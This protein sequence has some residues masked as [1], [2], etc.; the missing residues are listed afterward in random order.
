MTV[1]GRERGKNPI[2]LSKEYMHAVITE[3]FFAVSLFASLTSIAI[4]RIISLNT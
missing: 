1:R 3:L 4:S 2:S